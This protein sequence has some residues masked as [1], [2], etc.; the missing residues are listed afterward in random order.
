MTP[1]V[2]RAGKA[3]M[4]LS[5]VFA[6]ALV[7]VLNVPVELYNADGS[8][9]AALGAGIGA[10]IFSE[11]DLGLGLTCVQTIEPKN[12]EQY[13]SLFGEWNEWLKKE[14]N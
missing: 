10:G 13:N 14:L 7:D 2:I 5:N 9:G 8:V 1:T 11:D 12:P 3:N 4:F 6:Q